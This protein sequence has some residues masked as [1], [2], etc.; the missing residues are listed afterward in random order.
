MRKWFAGLMALS[1]LLAAGCG[2]GAS[3]NQSGGGNGEPVTIRFLSLAWQK[4]SVEANKEI[5]A[6][7][8]QAHPDIQ[9]EYIQGDWNSVHDYMLTSFESGD[10]PDVFH[11]DSSS[12]IDWA[13]RGYLKELSSLIPAEMKEDISPN[14][15]ATV[16]NENGEIYGIP[17]LWEALVTFYN[18]DRFE[19]AGITPPTADDPWTWDEFMAA[20]KQLTKDED[21]DGTPE[22]YGASWGLKSSANRVLN[23]SL[24]FNGEFFYE[25]NGK[26]V[27]RV[28]DPEKKVLQI[29]HDMMYVDKSASTDGIGQSGTDLLPG[30][31]A[32]KYAMLP[33]LG[34]WARQQIS[35]S[36]PEG[37]RWGV[38]PPFM[39]ENQ[40][41][42]VGTQTLSIPAEAEH[43]E[44]AMQF[45][46]FF[47]NTENMGR[48][49]QG[50]WVYPTRVSTMQLPEFQTDKDGW[51]E[52]AEYFDHMIL[53]RFTRVPGLEEWKSKVA[54]PVLQE[55]FANAITLEEAA[56]RLQDEGNPILERYAR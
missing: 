44:E 2:G 49:A 17:F 29:I 48:L 50:D 20:A 3:Q 31:Y 4:Q 39:G 56:R 36:A 1:L 22:Q 11:Y 23:L 19:E 33:G 47:L 43:P 46:E 16:T 34:V 40:N 6:A 51:K 54:N 27:I 37:F 30:F 26:T 21:G 53:A 12:I 35:E 42:G 41:Q 15:W 45:I 14:A 13:N 10:V 55:Y 5:V 7:W 9:V 25:E 18:V 24:G 8:N 32:G 52:S 28:G 38:L